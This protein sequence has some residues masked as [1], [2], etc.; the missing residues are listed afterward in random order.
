MYQNMYHVIEERGGLVDIQIELK[1]IC[2]I[3]A[4]KGDSG[5]T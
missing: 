3:R 4:I 2:H 5:L 1:R